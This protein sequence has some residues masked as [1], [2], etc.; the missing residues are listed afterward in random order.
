M[1]VFPTL[2]LE[3]DC[4]VYMEDVRVDRVVTTRARDL[5]KVYISCD[6]IIEKEY[7]YKVE[8]ELHK[9]LFSALEGGKEGP[10]VK[11]YETFH[12][13]A[14]YDA[15]AVF[16]AYK[17]SMLLELKEYSPMLHS[18]LKSAEL[19]FEADDKVVL[20]MEDIPLYH[21]KSG[22]LLQILDK[23]VCERCGVRAFFEVAYEEPKE[24][25]Y[26]EEDD[27]KIARR[28][29]EIAGNRAAISQTS[30]SEYVDMSGVD[31]NEFEHAASPMQGADAKI[32]EQPQKQPV[33]KAEPAQPPKKE[34]K[35]EGKKDFKSFRRQGRRS[36][37]PDVL[38]GYDVEGEIV[39]MDQ[40]LDEMGEITIRG[41][42]LSV[43]EREIRNE[44]TIVSFFITDFTDTMKCKMFCPNEELP[45]IREGVKKG[46]FLL[47]RGLCAMDSFDK[48]LTISI[49]SLQKT[50]DFTVTRMDHSA[51][52]R[53]ELHC[54][55]KMS[56]MDGVSDVIDI[57][58]RAYKWGHPAIAITDHGVVQ[59]LA[60]VF[61][62]W[63]DLYKGA[64]AEAEKEGKQ[65]D[66]Q[67]F[68][69]VICGCE[70]YLVDDLKN[71]VVNPK[72]QSLM[73]SFVVFDIE[74]T[75]FSS[76]TNHIIEI[77]A[78][79]V[80]N[81]KIVDRFS[82]YVNP[83]EPIPYRITK[84]T[85]ITDAD[86]MDAPT[87][88]QVLPEFFAFC[89][90]CVLVAH[91]ASF[92]TG[93]IKENARKLELPYAYTHV[94]TLAMARVLLP[95]L[96][97][98]T[99]DH[100]AKTVG[101]SL[102]NHHRA[103]DDAEATAEIFEKFIPMLLEKG[104]HDLDAVNELGRTSTDYVR[105]TP[106]YHA[107]VLAKNDVGRVNLYKLISASHLQYFNRRPKVP[108][109]LILENR[110][111]LILGSAC[112]A[113]ELYR[114]LLRG[115]PQA[116]IADIVN[117]Y[118]YLE[119][120]PNGN[121]AFM[122]D[123]DKSDHENIHSMEDIQE[124][125][126]KIC[127]L[128]EEFHKPVCATCDVHF[129]DPEDEV[130]RR[131]IMAGNGFKDADSQAPLYLRTTE[132]MLAEFEYL[133]S[134]KAREVVID[135]T[136][137]IAD[138]V[139]SIDPVRPDK[140]PPV[141]ENSDQTLTDICYRRA[142]E[143]Y[144][145]VL[146]DI[147]EKR[148]EKELNSIISNGFAVMYIIAQKLVWKSVEDGYLVGSRGSVGSSFVANMAGITEVNSLSPH[149][150]CK[151]CHY[152]DFDSPEVK[153]YAGKAGCDMPDKICPNCG[154]KLVKDGFDI[155]FETFLGFKGDKEP[156]IDLNFSGEYQS[157]AHKYTEVIF[158]YGQTFRAGT[159]GTLAEKTAY[160]YVMKYY[161]ER[162]IHKRR[163]EIER[164]A[165]GCTGVRRSTGQHPGGIVVLPLGEEINSFTPVQHPANDMTTDIVTTHFD[166]HKIDHNLLKLDI[167]GHDDPT[168][169]RMLQDLTGIDPTKIP[170]DDKDVMSLFQN[171]D[172]LGV[173]P[174]DILGCKLGSLGIP[175]FGTD[176]AMQ[177]LIDTQPTSFSDL[178][179]IAGLSHGTDVWLGN[180]QTLIEE[181]KATISTAICTRDD[182]MIYLMQM[183][184]EAGLS[185]TIMESVR[186]GKGLKD[187]WIATM[188]EHNVPDWYIWSCK[189]IKYM[190]PKAHAAAYVMMAWRI[191]YC[192]VNYP[193]AYYAAFYSIRADCF[194][195]ELMCQGKE[196]L[197]AVLA[198]YNRR[199]DELSKKE[200]DSI[201]DLR[202]VQEMYARGFE[203]MPIDIYKAHSRL[204]QIIDGKIMPSLGSIDGMGDK[205]AE[206]M[207][208]A[209]KDGPFLSRDDLRSR[210]KAPQ[211][212]IDKMG[213]LGL[214]GSLPQ[215]NQ[216]SLFDFM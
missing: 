88:D 11:L 31:E 105:K 119:I 14:Q 46:A 183:G 74:T 36:D 106:S 9:Q 60:D 112:E 166:Y 93:F 3:G 126:K 145:E 63:Q 24:S 202:I 16:G 124:I 139:D 56:D 159:I 73:D 172:A 184:V 41:K 17:N 193:L 85:T 165:E 132:E 208:E 23:I 201:R 68:F 152:Y 186:K 199:K 83:Q 194:S 101:V 150:Y 64:K 87:I 198:D 84:L 179:R 5:L 190:F 22:E 187:E 108:K 40:I 138:M 94:D 182:I 214:L 53:V 129:L 163:C 48:D 203:F 6:N 8:K 162:G 173:K 196:H 97:K 59:A 160:G 29:A 33:Q 135:N 20:T 92:D 147:V 117:F 188:K 130:Y 206:A 168:M 43:E 133:G 169:I 209:A 122:I 118:D 161:E 111:G 114:A 171:T 67:D 192:K 121:N 148:L 189:K 197:E 96:A 104:A 65:L 15:P 4:K 7:I 131:I 191:A 98:F 211:N 177:M 89:E 30:D 140:C 120:Q 91:N 212:V 71:I 207:M 107:I 180:A 13:S 210:S 123:S 49:K 66:R 69:K 103:V 57:V 115:A 19:S 70:I 178:V 176:F 155:P 77:G 200:Q 141:I 134:D 144:G 195:Y 27:I 205:A 21:Q 86:V 157:K 204:F 37:N 142:H 216:L 52:K 109:S 170:L 25:K 81:G 72:G 127:D 154:E 143:I 54:H 32:A 12:L 136:N 79:K 174:E 102:E 38:Y 35:K 55:T 1:E 34:F 26:R 110:E 156:D 95:Q 100:V 28:I 80:E 62:T 50:K 99:L 128:G 116:E 18:M 47:V 149:Y 167:L 78:V 2:H 175:E 153:A 75:G 51:K 10:E 215:S 44:K 76:V 58:K 125:N 137:L 185:F 42:V 113:G 90:G 39:P 146:P 181:G 213:E 82:T 151:K 61:H 45:N 164:I 158:G